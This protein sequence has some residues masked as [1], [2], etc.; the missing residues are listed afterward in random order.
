[1]EVEIISPMWFGGKP[2]APG[3]EGEAN[4]VVDMPVSDAVY[5]EGLGRV[6]RVASDAPKTKPAKGKK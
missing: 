2:M 4:P 6:R 1:M 3:A 5:L